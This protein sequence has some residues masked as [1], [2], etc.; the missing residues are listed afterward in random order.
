[1]GKKA[2]RNRT[3]ILIVSL[4]LIAISAGLIWFFVGNGTESRT[5]NS[6]TVISNYV[7]C[8]STH[9][10]DP[11]LYS[12]LSND[13][14]YEIKVAFD[15]KGI[16]T[17]S[18]TYTGTFA[19]AKI[20]EEE[21]SRLLAK[22]NTYMGQETPYKNGVLSPAFSPVNE[23]L[24]INLFMARRYL[25]RSTAK[26]IFLSEAEYEE[27]EDLNDHEE[28]SNKLKTFYQGKEFICEIKD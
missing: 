9:P 21:S 10:T 2:F 11:F 5:H 12:T 28:I 6:E 19:D 16:S 22:Y 14:N 17:L 24:V 7:D 13:S 15:E 18:F 8:N 4:V 1:M 26:L 3:E 20:A 23:N 25:D 27:I